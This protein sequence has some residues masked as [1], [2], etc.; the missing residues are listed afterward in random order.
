MSVE[1]KE[2]KLL[3][4][5][6]ESRLAGSTAAE[7]ILNVLK[8]GL[9]TAPFCGGIASLITDYI[10]SSRIIRLEEFAAR[11]AEDL[12]RLQGEVREEYLHTDDFAF[13]FEKCFKRQRR[14][15]SRK[16]LIHFEEFW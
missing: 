9:A 15:G 1:E 4:K 8:A 7:T 11:I 13:M 12:E 2:N 10:P 14:I 5:R 6:M 3:V 16:N